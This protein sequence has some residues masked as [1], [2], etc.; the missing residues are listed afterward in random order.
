MFLF[1]L[2]ASLAS[3][4]QSAMTNDQAVKAYLRGDPGVK[5]GPDFGMVDT[6]LKPVSLEALKGK[7]VVLDFWAS[8][9]GPCVESLPMLKQLQ[10]DYGADKLKVISITLDTHRDD[11]DR[12]L[13]EHAMDWTQIYG[14]T[15]L[16]KA[17]NI[18][19][20]PQVVLIGPDGNIA[21]LRL[22]DDEGGKLTGDGDYERLKALLKEK[23][24]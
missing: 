15:D 18:G 8:R 24:R 3:R 13:K 16:I 5:G 7:Y 11:F 14:N 20:I 21:Y 6:A 2:S 22:Y 17:Y 9:C 1:W 10:K 4:A 19:P 23:I 12:A